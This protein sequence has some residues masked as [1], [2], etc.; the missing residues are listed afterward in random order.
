MQE[1][2]SIPEK[3]CYGLVKHGTRSSESSLGDGS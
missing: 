3:E 1:G 2:G